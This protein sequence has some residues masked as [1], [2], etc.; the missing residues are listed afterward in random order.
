MPAKASGNSDSLGAQHQER[1]GVGELA[2]K[3]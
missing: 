1:V 2:Q 3:R